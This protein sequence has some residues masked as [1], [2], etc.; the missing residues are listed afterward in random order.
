MG[1]FCEALFQK[2]LR[3]V[4]DVML[5]GDVVRKGPEL[6]LCVFITGPGAT[7]SLSSS[8][9]QSTFTTKSGESVLPV[10]VT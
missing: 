1:S 4:V 7:Y 10:D 3:V 5:A 9:K 2:K 8:A 6:I